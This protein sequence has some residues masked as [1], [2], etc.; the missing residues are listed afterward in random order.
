[1]QTLFHR[2]FDE[3]HRG[4]LRWVF[5]LAVPIFI[6]ELIFNSAG[7]VDQLMIGK[8]GE[9]VI[10]A[11]GLANQIFFIMMLMC[12]GITSG[13]SALIGQYWGKREEGV[14][15]TQDIRKVIGIALVFNL[16]VSVAF[17]ILANILPEQLLDIY[18]NDPEVIR[19]GT[20]YLKIVAFAFFLSPI[21]VTFS[22]AFRSTQNTKIPMY[23]TGVSLFINIVLNYIFIYTLGYGVK[24]AAAATVIARGIELLLL[25]A[26]LKVSKH[27]AY[28]NI[29]EYF[30]IDKEILKKYVKIAFPVMLNELTWVVGV[31]MY[32]VAFGMRG[33]DA[34]ASVLMA[35]SIKSFFMVG[36]IAVGST[37]TI[38]I[39]N[40]LG[41]GDVVKVRTYA[42]RYTKLAVGIAGVMAVVM[43]ASAPLVIGVYDV[44]EEVARMAMTNCYIL[45]TV[46][47]FQTY[48]YTGIVGILRAGGDNGFCLALDAFAV[49]CVA[50]P[51]VFGIAYFTELPLQYV[52]F[53]SGCEEYSKVYFL[54]RRL[55]SG[56][57]ANVLV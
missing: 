54:N 10:S 45:A 31:S 40:T 46:F 35:N 29:V 5:T 53:A 34:Q 20:D 23:C 41:T 39:S 24:G 21:N 18:S 50:I 16:T 4:F 25:I 37:A 43:V 2:Y 8:L 52:V 36:G 27:V 19:I 44:S 56:Q 47:M 14:D 13:A 32:N 48:N 38:V 30:K 12:F 51:L 9:E 17:F 26:G 1:M 57:W 49:W 22:T 7:L 11:V 55:K 28:C 33:T 42:E 6:Q 15:S 3:E